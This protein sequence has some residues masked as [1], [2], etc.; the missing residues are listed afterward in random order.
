M[1]IHD[2]ARSFAGY[3][4]WLKS[5]SFGKVLQ[6]SERCLVEKTEQAP[7]IVPGGE[8]VSS[9]V[10]VQIRSMLTEAWKNA[11]PSA[12]I[13][14]A[15]AKFESM[16]NQSQLPS[17]IQVEQTAVSGVPS[18]WV[19]APEAA[20]DRVI[21]HLHGGAHVMGSCNTE[22]D[23]AARLSAA[24]QARV[25]LIEYHLAPEHPFPAALQDAV[26]AYDWLLN[27]GVKPE[28]LAI[29]GASSG[30]GLAVATLVSIRDAGHPLPAAAVLIS[31]WTDLL[32]S[33]A[34]MTTRAEIDPWLTPQVLNFTAQLYLGETDGRDPLASPLYA[35]LHNL[36]PVLIHAGDDEILLDDSTRLA[37]H[38]RAAGVEVTLDI[39]EGMWHAWHAFAADLPEGQ[40]AIEDVGRFIRQQTGDTTITA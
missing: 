13:E 17:D 27:T 10:S 18:E 39:W 8:A 36:P 6:V 32:C 21:L 9:P 16:W 23:L 25:L 1:V 31:P 34:S 33:G 19:T 4:D 29:L 26:A 37:Q 2:V 24:S 12:T 15:R 40:Q 20:P 11:P 14:E 3:C 28:R 7:E 38:A 35:D 5:V 30:G 22:R